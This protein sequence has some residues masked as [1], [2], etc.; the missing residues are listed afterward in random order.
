ML[1]LVDLK[2][3]I[4]KEVYG[5]VFKSDVNG[6]RDSCQAD[7]ESTSSPWADGG[8]SSSVRL[9]LHWRGVADARD[10]PF[11][12]EV[13]IVHS[14]VVSEGARRGSPGHDLRGNDRVAAGGHLHGVGDT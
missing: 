9:F 4:S 7:L 3:K 8:R 5:Q 2:K 10:G 1:E 13:P 6:S 14:G 12:G 11:L